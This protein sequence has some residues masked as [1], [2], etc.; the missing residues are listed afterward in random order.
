M[1]ALDHSFIPLFHGPLS[2]ELFCGTKFRPGSISMYVFIRTKGVGHR[3]HIAASFLVLLA[4]H[5]VGCM[6]AGTRDMKLKLHD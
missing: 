5:F 6:K 4:P 3:K 1:T 2:I